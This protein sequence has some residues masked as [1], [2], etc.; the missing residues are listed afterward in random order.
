VTR[1]P[2][3]RTPEQGFLHVA[4]VVRS[5]DE[6]SEAAT[7]WTREGVDAGDLVV[8][9]G[10]PS[11]QQAVAEDFGDVDRVWFDDRVRPNGRRGPDAL[12]AVLAMSQQAVQD[13]SGRLRV[14]AQ[15]DQPDDGRVVREFACL[16]S[17]ANLMPIAAPTATLCI[18]DERRLPQ[19][20]IRTAAATH[21][22]LFTTEGVRANESFVDPH[23]FVRGLAVPREPLQDTV[24]L[25]AVDEA[26]SLADLRHALGAELVRAVDDADRR[27]DLHLA[28]SEMAANAFRHGGRPVGARL[29]ASGDRLVCTISDA[30]G[31]VDPLRGYWPAHGQDLGQGGMGLWLAR[32]LC[33]HV[34]L[35]SD[36]RGT[37]VRLATALR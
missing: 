7:R 21:P 37:T 5:D 28:I 6:L 36:E 12:A 25:L 2:A 29:W 19:E 23:E 20:L 32:K 1:G 22:G 10:T 33:D 15:V 30:G 13:G 35:M 9:G 17:A 24:P 27:E 3:D 11:F 31:G 4:A 26:T 16:E 14:L 8:V 18:Y 34:D